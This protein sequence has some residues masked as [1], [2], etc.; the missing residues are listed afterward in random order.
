ML[1]ELYQEKTQFERDKNGHAMEQ[2]VKAMQEG[3]GAIR[4]IILDNSQEL[5]LNSYEIVD[6]PIKYLQ[7]K[8]DLSLN[9][10]GFT[11]SRSVLQ[12]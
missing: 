10:P 4:D 3:L 11:L 2:Q 1:L 9:R 8:N 12:V 5:Y 6:K 7:A